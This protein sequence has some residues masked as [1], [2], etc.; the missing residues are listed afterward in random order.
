[1]KQGKNNGDIE[2]NSC[3]NTSTSNDEPSYNDNEISF[4]QPSLHEA[5]KTCWE[6]ILSNLLGY[7][8]DLLMDEYKKFNKLKQDCLVEYKESD[9][10][11]E[12]ILKNCYQ[13]FLEVIRFDDEMKNKKVT[14]KTLGFQVS[15]IKV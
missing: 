6:Y 12:S 15:L 5:R 3:I 9:S 8:Y 13:N 11:H 7:N 2:H 1:M 4:I 10:D 14:W